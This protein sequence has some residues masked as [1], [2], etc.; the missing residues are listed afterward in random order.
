MR[1]LS[2]LGNEYGE[3]RTEGPE[4]EEEGTGIY[5]APIVFFYCAG[6]FHAGTHLI[7]AKQSC[8]ESIILVYYLE[9]W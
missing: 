3:Q 8:E 5:W 9:T 7:L 6:H 4:L 1:R 2:H